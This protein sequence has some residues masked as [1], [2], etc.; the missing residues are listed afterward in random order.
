MSHAPFEPS[1]LTAQRPGHDGTAPVR[2]RRIQ[3]RCAVVKS[4]T[5]CR[6]A[7]F[8]PWGGVRLARAQSAE[9]TRFFLVGKCRLANNLRDST[10]DTDNCWPH[11]GS[12]PV[13]S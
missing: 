4:T 13:Q 3:G 9:L 8:I 2:G 5:P 6:Q 7:D 12:R 11:S 10:G 1:D